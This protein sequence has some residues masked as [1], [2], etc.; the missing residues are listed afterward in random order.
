MTRPN[1]KDHLVE[2]LGCRQVEGLTELDPK[3]KLFFLIHSSG[4]TCPLLQLQKWRP[5][6]GFRYFPNLC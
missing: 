6:N 5:L 4:V 1:T 3:P 2:I